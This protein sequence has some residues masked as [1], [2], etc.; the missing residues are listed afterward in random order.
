MPANILHVVH[1]AIRLNSYV[2]SIRNNI[3]IN[4]LHNFHLLSNLVSI[5]FQAT[6]KA[7]LDG[8]R[9]SYKFELK[10]HLADDKSSENCNFL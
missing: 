2:V 9:Q 6:P 3:N 10:L 8:I 4:R 5:L 1:T 7:S